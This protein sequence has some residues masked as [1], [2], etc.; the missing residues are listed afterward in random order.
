MRRLQKVILL[1]IAIVFFALAAYGIVYA[2]NKKMIEHVSEDIIRE[3]DFNGIGLIYP[4]IF[5]Y[6]K[7]N[8]H[9]LKGDY[10]SAYSEYSKALKGHVPELKE[11]DIRINMALSILAELKPIEEITFDDIDDTLESLYEASDILCEDSCATVEEDGLWHHYD[12]Q[13]LEQEILD[14]IELL[15]LLKDAQISIE[16]VQNTGNT[17]N[18]TGTNSA[19][20]GQEEQPQPSQSELDERQNLQDKLLE[21]QK[22]GEADRIQE[23]N[24]RENSKNFEFYD[25][26]RW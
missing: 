25:G 9:Y 26:K 7:G 11:C 8:M 18:S 3:T 10:D 13:T 15:E 6:N 19:N 17:G 12:A 2:K 24:Y 23:L 22:Q 1:L 16:E 14:Y 4:Y 20:S 21:S 5:H